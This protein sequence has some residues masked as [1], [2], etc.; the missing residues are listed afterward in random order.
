MIYKR[1]LYA[2]ICLCGKIKQREGGW[3]CGGGGGDFPKFGNIVTLPAIFCGG[4][5][6]LPFMQM[7]P[8]L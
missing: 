4:R 1:T 6:R 3:M 2:N 5:F 8:H 7:A